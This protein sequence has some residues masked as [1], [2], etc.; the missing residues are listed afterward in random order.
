REHLGNLGF[1]EIVNYRV[2]EAVQAL[3]ETD[4]PFDIIFND[5]DKHAYPESLPVIAEKLRPGGAL[6]IDNMLWHGA[7]FDQADQSPATAGIREFTR[8]ITTDPGWI[9]TLVPIRDGL[10]V[11]HRK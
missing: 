8:L 9:A 5:I 7:I 10:I 3:R 1:G 6:I 2:S 4:G 11:A